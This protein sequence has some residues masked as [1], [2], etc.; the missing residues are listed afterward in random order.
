MPHGGLGVPNTMTSTSLVASPPQPY[1]I[2]SLARR[3]RLLP[4][5]GFAIALEITAWLPE[6]NALV[7]SPD[8]YHQYPYGW[9]V[10]GHLGE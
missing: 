8:N 5:P 10:R 9:A 1:L 2:T 3:C 4:F 6:A 7:V